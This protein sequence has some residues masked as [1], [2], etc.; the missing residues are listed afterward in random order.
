MTKIAIAATGNSKQDQVDSHF[1]RCPYFF[2]VDTENEEYHAVEN[3]AQKAYGGAGISA[4][5]LIVDSKAEA[6]IT[7]NIGPKA[8]SVLSQTDVDIYL[9]EKE[10]NIE[11]ALNAF[12]KG[13]LEK[14][15]KANV[16]MGRG[17]RS[18]KSI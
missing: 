9:A 13:K 12:K 8:V 5:Q 17:G 10:Q 18:R 7:K 1:G 4:A 15:I 3:Q 14:I 11:Q 16:D 6:V 2:F